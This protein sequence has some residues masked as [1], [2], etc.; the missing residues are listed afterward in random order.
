MT[1]ALAYLLLT[2]MKNFMAMRLRRL[3]Q[4]KYLIG[5]LVGGFYFLYLFGLRLLFALR[6]GQAAPTVPTAEDALLHETIA[7]AIL[8]A[9][10]L[11]SWIIPS[12][13]AALVFTEAE[14]AFLFPAPVD[15]RTL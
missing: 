8:F 15:R 5:L 10:V 11:M 9:I 3:K 6:P 1:N 14:I 13:R 2:S 7:A 4:P 12:D